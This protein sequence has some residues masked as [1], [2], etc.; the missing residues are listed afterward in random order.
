VEKAFDEIPDLRAKAVEHMLKRLQVGF[1]LFADCICLL[2]DY[3][4]DCKNSI[5]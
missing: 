4:D 3:K 1:L 5:F 2:R